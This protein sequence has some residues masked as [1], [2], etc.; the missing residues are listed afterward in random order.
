MKPCARS[1]VKYLNQRSEF[2]LETSKYMFGQIMAGLSYIHAHNVIHRDI[3]PG[4]ILI[5][6]DFTVKIADFGIEFELRANHYGSLP[7]CAL[8]LMDVYSDHDE[9]VDIFSAGMI[10]YE[11]FLPCMDL[12]QRQAKLNMLPKKLRESVQ[13]FDLRAVLSATNALDNWG[14]NLSLLEK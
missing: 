7:Y 5:E 14:G 2:N 9:K 8:E 6:D 3:K 1:L 4:N 13:V 10:Y 12:K 11:L